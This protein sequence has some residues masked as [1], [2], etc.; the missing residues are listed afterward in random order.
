ME[1]SDREL[2]TLSET[3][4]RDAINK[5][6]QKTMAHEGKIDVG[7]MDAMQIDYVV[8]LIRGYQAMCRG[9][10]SKLMQITV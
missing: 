7:M 8:H 3:D 5:V 2:R 9:V 4:Y 1:W 10:I 6:L